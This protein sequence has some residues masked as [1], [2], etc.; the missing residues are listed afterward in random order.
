MYF[1][2]SEQIYDEYFDVF[3]LIFFTDLLCFIIFISFLSI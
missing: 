3:I 1:F 2:H